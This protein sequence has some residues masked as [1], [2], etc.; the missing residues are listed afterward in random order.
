[1]Q[2]I[3]Q[4]ASCRADI[5][6]LPEL[7]AWPYF[8]MT[9][10]VQCFDTAQPI[11]GP[12]TASLSAAAKRHNMIIVTT[13]FERRARG[14]YHNTALVIDR[15]RGIAG[16]YRKMHIPQDPGFC[17]KFY[18]APGQ[19]GFLPIRTSCCTLG[20]LV[21]WDQWFPEA[22]RLMALAGADI[23]LYPSAIAWSAEDDREEC[24]RQL[25]AWVTVQRG[26]AI[27][28]VMPV[29]VSNR[30]GPESCLGKKSCHF[31]GNSFIAGC[32]GELL[33]RAGSQ[34]DA[35]L[36]TDVDLSHSENVRRIWPF[37]RDRRVD[38]YADLVQQY[39]A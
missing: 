4:A 16:R 7:Y 21:C 11:P 1:M 14:L 27:A 30:V 31:W 36:I 23:L 5:L 8:C 32:Q 6:L 10:R 17:E 9:E 20:V 26:H 19:Q 24:S 12:L 39:R 28:N 3:E 13:L 37:F 15:G 22:A 29:A 35:L 33:A 38:Q 2:A 18:F 25:S 34:E